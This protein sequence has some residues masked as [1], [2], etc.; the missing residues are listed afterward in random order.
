MRCRELGASGNDLELNKRLLYARKKGLTAAL[1]KV[2]RFSL[3]RDKVDQYQYGSEMAVRY[4][5]RKEF[6]H[7]C[8]EVSLDTIICDPIL[9]AAFDDFAN[10]IAPGF[11]AFEYRWA[12]LS[13]R[14]AGRYMKD[15]MAIEVPA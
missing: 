12:A 15:A 3:P 14:K 8:Q 11:T 13:L 5:Q 7:S 1:P 2:P 6:E 4:V 9:A 10:R